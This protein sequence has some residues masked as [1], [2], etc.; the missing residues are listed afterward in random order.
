MQSVSAPKLSVLLVTYNHAAYVG[1]A[2]DSVFRQDFLG[3]IELVVADDASSDDTVNIIRSYEN[4]DPRFTF[5]YLPNDRNLGITRNYQRA[6]A[7]CSGEYIAVIEGDDI[8]VHR[9]KLTKQVA[10][11]DEHLEC[12]LCASNYFIWNKDA[13]RYTART[14]ADHPGFMY[15]DTPFIINDNL[16][17]NFSAIVYRSEV[18]K[19][20]PEALF[21]LK[22]Y[23]WAVNICAGMHG[24]FAYLHEP[25]S[26]Y[27]VH[28]K[29]AW[30]GLKLAEKL[31]EQIHSAE[32]YNK[33]TN[34]LYESEFNELIHRLKHRQ[35][36]AEHVNTFGLRQTA[37]RVKRVLK[38][39]TP[40]IV[41]S[42]VRL[43]LPP[44]VLRL[45]AR[46]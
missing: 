24:L 30:S 4:R 8:W 14:S 41:I 27:R 12:V 37:R 38:A 16:P 29:G 40:P 10:L 19:K 23:D 36:V 3:E 44:A 32:Q 5:R 31:S 43:L 25:L 33:L 13:G 39:V 21:E 1:E 26:A 45:L 34:N 22:A 6:F 9:S 2:L 28:D 42:I 11:L 17:G 15:F 7:A 20:L 18:L 46:A 35:I